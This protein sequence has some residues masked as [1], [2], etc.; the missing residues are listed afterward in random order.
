MERSSS[1]MGRGSLDLPRKSSESQR[2]HPNPNPYSMNG[3]ISPPQQ[4]YTPYG[5]APN[6]AQQLTSAMSPPPTGPPSAP[7]VSGY[8]PFGYS[9]APVNGEAPAD[10]HPQPEAADSQPGYQAPSY[11]Y[12]P[13]SFTPYEAPS[14]DRNGKQNGVDE[15]TETNSYE[16]PSYQPYGFEPPSYE[17]D[18]EPAAEDSGEES[19]KPKPKKK[20][21]MY[22][23]DD[24][25]P[26]P[27]IKP[28]GDKSDKSK[29]D[30]DRE[31]AEMF[32]KAA[33][34]DGEPPQPLLSQ[35]P[36]NPPQSQTRR[37]GQATRRQKGLGLH[38]LVRR[39]RLQKGHA[40]GRPCRWQP[41]QAHPRQARRGQLVLLRPRAKALGQQERRPQGRPG[42]NNRH[43]PAAQEHPALRLGQPRLAP[44][45]SA[46]GR[47]RAHSVWVRRRPRQR[48]AHGP[49]EVGHAVRGWWWVADAGAAD[50]DAL[51]VEYEHGQRA[52]G[53][54]DVEAEQFE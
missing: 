10:S 16:A 43:P 40:R 26:M 5:A 9:P 13:P 22:D 29:E 1:E 37:R 24:D 31:N 6:A 41:Q 20:G 28:S 14:D 33:E 38:Q 2:G 7:A 18:S 42:Q 30:K 4:G 34:E 27:A 3:P 21:I 44:L 25:L 15:N 49:A 17:P 54:A 23:D 32:R 36:T 53:Q 48:P 52:R 11:G 47:L 50:D 19:S 45:G 51:C 46:H 8:T 39:Q 12:E 35:N